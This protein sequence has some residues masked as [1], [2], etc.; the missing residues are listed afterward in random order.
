MVDTSG[1]DGKPCRQFSK[2]DSQGKRVVERIDWPLLPNAKYSFN[3]PSNPVFANTD[4]EGRF[5]Y[6]FKNELQ[7]EQFITS[8]GPSYETS[9]ENCDNWNIM[10]MNGKLG[11]NDKVYLSYAKTLSNFD[12]FLFPAYTQYCKTHRPFKCTQKQLDQYPE[13]PQDANCNNLMRSRTKLLCVAPSPDVPV[14]KPVYNTSIAG[15]IYVAKEMIGASIIGADASC[16]AKS[17]IAGSKAL[18]VDVN[19]CKGKPCRRASIGANKGDGQIDWPL[20]SSSTYTYLEDRTK[21]FSTTNEK[22]LFTF[23][24][25][26]SDYSRLLGC[27]NIVTGLSSNWVTRTQETCQNWNFGFQ[28]KMGIGSTCANGSAF[29]SGNTASCNLLKSASF[30]CVAP[31]FK[32]TTAAPQCIHL[33]YFLL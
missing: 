33:V 30:L 21:I 28:T 24:G 10:Y 23:S 9:K 27:S 2:F 13:R 4:S 15:Y 26:V 11:N 1:C 3:Y 17:K 7:D 14:S 6:F 19:G 22:G 18:I 32:V 5:T 25:R 31:S 16:Y 29:I 20:L 8:L 12:T